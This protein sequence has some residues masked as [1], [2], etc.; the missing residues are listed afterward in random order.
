[1]KRLSRLLLFV[2]ILCFLSLLAYA[3]CWYKKLPENGQPSVTPGTGGIKNMLPFILRLQPNKD[4]NTNTTPVKRETEG[5][6]P[7]GALNGSASDKEKQIEAYYTQ[8]LS[9]VASGYR[10]KLNSLEA[11]GISE[12]NKVREKKEKASLVGL[13]LKYISAGRALE[14]QCD[15]EINPILN[16]YKAE[17]RKNSLPE[18][19]AENAEKEYKKAKAAREK[20]I[21][22]S[23]AKYIGQP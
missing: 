16:E 5:E 2:V 10:Q 9:A 3:G 20:Q 13:A 17:L 21:L 23:A 6:T 8:K 18:Y 4:R 15:A 1:M 14:A 7:S 12:Y 19:A 11:E 22:S